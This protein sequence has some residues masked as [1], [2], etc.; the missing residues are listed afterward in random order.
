MQRLLGRSSTVGS[1]A[2]GRTAHGDSRKWVAWR[3]WHLV[4]LTW[5]LLLTANPCF[6]ERVVLVRPAAS[7]IVLSEIFNR[8]QGELRMHGFEAILASATAVPASNDL[9]RVAELGQAMASV[10]L[11]RVELDL[12]AHVWFI[13]RETREARVMSI[14]L[15]ET[16]ET[17]ALLA[18]R[19]VELLRSGLREQRESHPRVNSA[20]TP[21]TRP[22]EVASNPQPSVP[23]APPPVVHV[24]L[25]LEGGLVWTAMRQSALPAL[26]LSGGY[27]IFTGW[28]IAARLSVPIGANSLSAANSHADYRVYFL[29][30]ESRW[31][32]AFVSHRVVLEPLVALGLARCIGI[33][34]GDYPVSGVKSATWTSM[35]AIGVAGFFAVTPRLKLGT[36]TRL[37]VLAP[38]PVLRVEER[39]LTLGRPWLELGLALNYGF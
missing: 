32:I 2:R 37:G 33:G 14:A 31:P 8:L 25:R 4:A 35:A 10:A 15:E 26:G 20:A 17:P 22:V 16:E 5:S 7:D 29:G 21:P 34:H 18:L 19:T 6:A 24:D 38:K 23:P 3:V 39:G 30:A 13:D 1:L 36:S 27:R 9:Q 11:E 12:A 28:E